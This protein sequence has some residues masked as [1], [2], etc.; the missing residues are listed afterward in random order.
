MPRRSLPRRSRQRGGQ[1][2]GV[3]AGAGSVGETAVTNEAP[4]RMRRPCG[5]PRWSRQQW[6]VLSPWR[7]RSCRPKLDPPPR[8]PHADAAKPPRKCR[9]LPS[10]E[11][12]ITRL[13]EP[14]LIE[15]W[16]PGRAEVV[17]NA[18]APH[19]K[20]ANR[21]AP[22]L[23]RTRPRGR[24]ATAAATGRETP[25]PTAQDCPRPSRPS[26]PRGTPRP[27]RRHAGEHQPR[28]VR[29]ANASGRRS[30]HASN[31]ARGPPTPISPFAKLAAL[32]GSARGC[33]KERR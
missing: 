14:V 29:S 24:E 25:P 7:P 10:A 9:N 12:Q 19:R 2:H 20:E 27:P 22:R 18:A 5:E 32:K 21:H 31:G 1:C 4:T 30:E 28:T 3:I 6:T 17:G 33:A 26:K 13:R 11:H 15:V 23:Q 16:R 8:W